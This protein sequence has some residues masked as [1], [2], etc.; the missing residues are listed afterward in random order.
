[1]DNSKLPSFSKSDKQIADALGMSVSDFKKVKKQMVSD[2]TKPKVSTK[3]TPKPKATAMGRAVS[4]AKPLFT[5]KPTPKFTAPS[6]SQYKSSAAYKAGN[7]T[8]KQ[9]IDASKNAFDIK[10]K[11]K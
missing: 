8:Y 1:M 10:N 5:A 7:M 6:L 3:P 11:K 4:K 2:I 9:Y